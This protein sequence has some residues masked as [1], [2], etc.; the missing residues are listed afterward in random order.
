M[1]EYMVVQRNA[2]DIMTD[3]GAATRRQV[4]LVQGKHGVAFTRC[5]YSAADGTRFFLC[6]APSKEAIAAAHF[7][8]Y[9]KDADEILA[10][11]ESFVPDGNAMLGE[12]LKANYT[13]RDFT[14]YFIGGRYVECDFTG[15]NLT[16]ARL[17]G[18]FIRCDF[19]GAVFV[20]T[21]LEGSFV[22]CIGL[23]NE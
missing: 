17:N 3:G 6:V 11:E 14:A 9:G 8:V 2:R 12:D 23:P 20:Q 22:D 15:T 18:Q 5:W 10:E 21:L 7:A 19:R 13:N 16:N 4:L 1:P